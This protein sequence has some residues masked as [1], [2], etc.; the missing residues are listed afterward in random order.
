M[1]DLNELKAYM[2]SRLKENH[3]V[4]HL[5]MSLGELR[6]GYA[7]VWLDVEERHLQHTGFL[8][9]GVTASLLD[10]S[11]GIAAYTQAPAGKNVVTAE[12]KISYLNPSV[13]ARVKAIG[14]VRKA[15]Q[16]LLF[17]E[18][19]LYDVQPDGEDRLVGTA[20]SLMIAVDIPL[21]NQNP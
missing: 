12:L 5:G 17:C 9:G 10:V 8:H 7:E 13:S 11:T 15:G 19:E 16:T 2:D 6:E 21:K 4:H 14:R 3:F 20:T 1:K 18:G